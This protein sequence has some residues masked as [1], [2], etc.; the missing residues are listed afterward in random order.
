M[1]FFLKKLPA[2]SEIESSVKET[3]GEIFRAEF[4]ISFRISVFICV[5]LFGNSCFF[6]LKKL[7]AKSEIESSVKETGGEIFRA[8]FSIS[9]RISVF[10]FLIASVEKLSFASVKSQC[11]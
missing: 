1:F 4:S 2:K 8:E 3:G 10:R 9:F 11:T 6:F 7:P 5:N